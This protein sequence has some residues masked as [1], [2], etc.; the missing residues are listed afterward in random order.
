MTKTAL[1]LA[2]PTA[3]RGESAVRNVIAKLA[4]V[5]T[6]QEWLVIPQFTAATAK[7]PGDVSRCVGAGCQPAAPT[8]FLGSMRMASRTS[9]TRTARLRRQRGLMKLLWGLKRRR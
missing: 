5:Y 1:L 8:T 6:D 3:K 4:K 9:S 2:N 7:A